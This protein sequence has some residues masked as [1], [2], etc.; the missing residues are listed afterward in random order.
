MLMADQHRA[1]VLGCAGH[2]VVRTPH[3]D[4]LAAQGVRFNRVNCQGPLCMPARASILTERYV[5]DHEAIQASLQST[6]DSC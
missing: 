4:E 2:R 3:I 1:D 5:R 6:E